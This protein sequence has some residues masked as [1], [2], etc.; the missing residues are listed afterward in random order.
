MIT[1]AIVPAPWIDLLVVSLIG[2]VFVFSLKIG[3]LT[4][5]IYDVKKKC[6]SVEAELKTFQEMKDK[7]IANIKELHADQIKVLTD[8]ITT[9]EKEKKVSTSET[10][11]RPLNLAKCPI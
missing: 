6:S 9:F 4:E 8:T 1:L 3:Q 5:R 11:N 7:E 10:M 2:L